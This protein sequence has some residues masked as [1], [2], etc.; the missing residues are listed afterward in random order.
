MTAI[1]KLKKG[2][3][4]PI[5]QFHHWIFSGAVAKASDC[6]DG[7]I[8]AVHSCEDEHLGYAFVNT[9]S[10]IFAR[11]I[12]FDDADP[13]VALR[14]S[15]MAA[16]ALREAMIARDTNAY[17]LINSEAD[18]LPGLV[19]DKYD[20]V[21]VVQISTLG[22][23]KHEDLLCSL[24]QEHL[25]PRA[26]L[27]RYDNATQKEEGLVGGSGVLFGKG[28][29]R[30][31]IRENGLTFT[32]DIKEGQKT[33]FFL[34]QRHM[35]AMV[36][37]IAQ[38]KKVLNLFSYTGGF[39]VYALAGGARSAHSVD[40]ASNALALAI[41]NCTANGFSTDKHTTT[42]E[43]VFAF[44]RRDPLQYDLVIVDPPAFAKHKKDVVS[45]CRGYKDINR[46]IM[47]KI[48][49]RSL[50]LTCSCS[51]HIDAVLFQTVIFQAAHEAG[52]RVKI[53]G[54]HQLAY[55][56]PINVY[57]PESDYLKS[58]LLYVE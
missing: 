35:R 20:D 18:R 16:V 27:K 55:D 53:I 51:Y 50:L 38:G 39:S 15:F 28:S 11:M 40:T 43:D 13:L 7:E 44:V 23:Q 46:V 10:S 22:M 54:R 6:R 48:P 56:H 21:Y 29:D 24:I 30:V 12:S 25:Q 3:D 33:G 17:R 32:V 49:A 47:S 42:G 37:T 19:L 4:K 8:A 58:L 14:E 34:D 1:I 26:I 57:H 31:L 52:R 41:E 36:R 45:A 5:R 9:R 2:K